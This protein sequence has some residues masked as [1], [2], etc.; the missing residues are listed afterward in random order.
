MEKI[1]LTKPFKLENGTDISELT[2]DFDSLSTSD[3]RQIR[4]LEAQIADGTRVNVNEFIGGLTLSDSFRISTGFLAA[5]K[6]TPGLKIEDFLKLPI[7][8]AT[9][10]GS[11]AAFFFAD[12]D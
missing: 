2:L 12:V 5:V 9:K 7:K 11:A 4:R 10:L 8:D 3:F 6:G 1:I